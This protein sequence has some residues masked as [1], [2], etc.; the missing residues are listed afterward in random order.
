MHA[1]DLISSSQEVTSISSPCSFNSFLTILTLETGVT[2]EV[3]EGSPYLS[4]LRGM[5]FLAI[6]LPL[7]YSSLNTLCVSLS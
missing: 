5:P 1:H 4:A 7:A 2:E 6:I 3:L